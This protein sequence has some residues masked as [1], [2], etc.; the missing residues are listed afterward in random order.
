MPISIRTQ[1]ENLSLWVVSHPIGSKLVRC[2]YSLPVS[3]HFIPL[4]CLAFQ[5]N[6]QETEQ[7]PGSYGSIRAFFLR[8]LRKG[9]REICLNQTAVVSPADGSVIAMGKIRQSS[10]LQVKGK[11]YSLQ[12]LLVSRR[13]SQRFLNGQY[14]TIYMSPGKYHHVHAPFD[15]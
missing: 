6:Q 12:R 15:C 4:F 5:V 11:R 14:L 1:L 2:L 3:R 8:R 7:P 9:A 13:H 10:L